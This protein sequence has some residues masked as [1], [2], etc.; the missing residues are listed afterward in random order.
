MMSVTNG[1][2]VGHDEADVTRADSTGQLVYPPDMADEAPVIG[3]EL[4]I[5]LV[6]P[7]GTNTG[8][9]ASTICGVLSDYNYVPIPIKL[10]GQLPSSTAPL[11]EGEDDR[12]RRL[13][14][15]GDEFCRAHRSDT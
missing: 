12:V 8:D 3:P 9:L 15:A 11:G 7:I 13:I 2:G 1:P 6:T 10:S 14:A 5:G 4:V